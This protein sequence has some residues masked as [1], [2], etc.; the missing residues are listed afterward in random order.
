MLGLKNG[1]FFF[2]GKDHKLFTE[3]SPA[4]FFPFLASQ[5]FKL[6]VPLSREWERGSEKVGREVGDARVSRFAG[7]VK[8]SG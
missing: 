7:L 8:G 2:F 4:F 1:S 3:R 5:I 6:L